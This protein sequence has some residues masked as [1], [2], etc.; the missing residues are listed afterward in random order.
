MA[1]CS[2]TGW[3]WG[4]WSLAPS[5]GGNHLPGACLD[6]QDPMPSPLLPPF[7]SSNQICDKDSSFLLIP[8][9]L[10]KEMAFQSWVMNEELSKH[11]FPY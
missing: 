11:S 6:P 5:A 10:L 4:G 7:R 1:A 3:S 9:A 8:A 2:Q